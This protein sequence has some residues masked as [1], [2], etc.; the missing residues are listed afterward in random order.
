MMKVEIL[1][2]HWLRAPPISINVHI[3]F[4]NE[5]YMRLKVSTDASQEE[6]KSLYYREALRAHPDNIGMMPMKDSKTSVKPI[7]F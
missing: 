3:S 4:D 1:K 7:V 5:F 2:S 6:I